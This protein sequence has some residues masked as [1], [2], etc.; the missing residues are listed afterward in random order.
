MRLHLHKKQKATNIPPH[1]HPIPPNIPQHTAWDKN[2]L[3]PSQRKQKNSPNQKISHLHNQNMGWENTKQTHPH[4][5]E[6]KAS[7]KQTDSAP[8]SKNK[9]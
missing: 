6:N 5:E 7:N 9:P 2:H 3:A 4:K 8:A 1:P